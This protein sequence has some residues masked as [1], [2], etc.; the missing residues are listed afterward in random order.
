MTWVVMALMLGLASIAQVMLPASDW[1]GQSKW[2]FLLGLVVYY[3]L[4]RRLDVVL[5]GCFAAG[6]MQDVLSPIPLG[7]SSCCFLLAG[8]IVSR[9]QTLVMSDAVV[10]QAFFGAAVAGGVGL[11]LQG[12]LHGAIGTGM[13]SAGH[14]VLGYS[15]A[16]A[17][18]APVMCRL[19]GGLDR[20][21]GNILPSK[22]VE[23]IHGDLDGFAE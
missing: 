15:L 6:F 3:A 14:R 18:T 20:L 21:V 10:T 12:V 22:E 2:P 7:T 9:F 19:A 11:V 8:W 17:V 13:L 16:G 4:H 1:L 23:G 5:V